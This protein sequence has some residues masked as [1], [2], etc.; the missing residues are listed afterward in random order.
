MSDFLLKAL[1]EAKTVAISGHIRPDGDCVGSCLGLYNYIIDNYDLKPDVYLEEIPMSYRKVQGWEQVISKTQG[2]TYDV[3][4]ALDCGDQDRLGFS[5]EILNRAKKTICIDHH[6]SHRGFTDESEVRPQA[7]SS[8]EVLFDLLDEDR[9]SLRTAEC[10]YMGIICDTGCFK[11]SCTSEHTMCV[12]G[13]LMSK[14][15]NTARMIDEVFYEKTFMQNQLLGECLLR[16]HLELDG[17]C[18]ICDVPQSLLDQYHA[19]SS[20][21]EGVIDQMRLTRGVETAALLT[22]NSDGSW[23][24]SLRACEYVDVQAIAATYG[25]GGHIKAAGATISG[26]IDWIE[27]DLLAK[28]KEQI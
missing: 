13:K 3:F 11:Y 23:K 21:L 24:L 16:C 18:I 27:A 20:D 1:N 10:L 5:A 19:V 12:A 9:I 28:I 15:V 25:G 8:C 14:G 7:S 6:I 26:D 4:I 17:K 22:E 2:K